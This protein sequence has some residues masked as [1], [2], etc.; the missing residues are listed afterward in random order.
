MSET[1]STRP[2]MFTVFRKPSFTFMWLAELIS[3]MGSAL[4][5]LA[6]SL[7]VYRVAGTALSVGL[8]L[9]ATSAPTILVGLLAGVFVDRYDRKTILVASDFLRAGLIAL[10]PLLVR[11]NIVWIYIIV[12]L[13]SAVN[14][15]G[16]AAQ[17]S[18]LPELASEDDLSAANSLMTVS[19]HLATT[20]GFAAAGIISTIDVNMAFYIN[21]VSFA[22]SGILMVI[23]HIPPLPPVTDTSV[24]AIITNLNSGFKTVRDVPILKSLFAIIS[25]V[26]L[27]FGLQYALWVPFALKILG[28][29]DFQFGLLESIDAVG[30]V[31]GS[32]LMAALADRIREGQWLALSFVFMAL[33]GVG[34]SFSG[35][36]SIAIL[37]IGLAGFMNAPSFIGRLLVIQRATPRE[38][39][40]RVN[41]SFFVVRDSMFVIGM[42]LA[43]LG[44]FV[45]VRLLYFV[46]SIGTLAAGVAILLIPGFAQPWS[47]WRRLFHR[48]RG[49][50]AAPRLGGG[51]PATLGEIEKFIAARPELRGMGEKDRRRLADQTMVAEAPGGKLVVYRGETSNAA[52]FILR[53]KVG[54]GYI[55][56]DEYVILN[57]LQEGDFFGEIAALT[58]AART[59]NVI[60]EEDSS[61]L[62]LPSKVLRS[63][64]AT[65]PALRQV[66]YSTMTERLSVADAPIGSRLDQGLLRELRTDQPSQ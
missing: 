25:P 11:F 35:T 16:D 12:A 59:A 37:L 48:L 33:A 17:A 64:A 21:A 27:I 13:S 15:F 14:Q 65:H 2:S 29:N 44:D 24:K 40:G 58:G 20:I 4:T 45:S 39:R 56:D 26:F 38:M 18:V 5:T 61:F 53:G 62:I 63:L 50:E 6:S 7:L 34:Y 41:S 9:I 52:Y 57:Y 49:A 23:T 31:A 30:V 22:V 47:E 43:G 3:G 36:M 42:L 66:F 60:T 1:S 28:G 51:I 46:G 54:I 19:E 32:L 55:R 8:M 10:I